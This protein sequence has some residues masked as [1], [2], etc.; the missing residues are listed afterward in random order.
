MSDVEFELSGPHR[1]LVDILQKSYY[2]VRSEVQFGP[3]T[4]D[5]YLPEHH[6][7]IEVDGPH[8]G[9]KR[10]AHRDS[11]LMEKWSLPVLR[12]KVSSIVGALE[13][14]DEWIDQMYDEQASRMLDYHA[15]LED[16]E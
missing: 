4:V 8:H 16:M 10:E 5:I 2:T 11:Y 14:I 7:A 1:K 3:Y 15:A 12:V 13:V 6:V 9:K